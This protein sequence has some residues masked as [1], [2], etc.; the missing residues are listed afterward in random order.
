VADRAVCE[1]PYR[2]L[3][4][5]RAAQSECRCRDR[6]VQGTFSQS[7]WELDHRDR[8]GERWEFNLEGDPSRVIPH[9]RL[10]R[11][12]GLS[13]LRSRHNPRLSAPFS[14]DRHIEFRIVLL[15]I[16]HA[17]LC[18]NFSTTDFTA[19][20]PVTGVARNSAATPRA[21]MRIE[22]FSSTFLYHC[23]SEPC[24]GRR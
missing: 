6:R 17:V 20:A 19:F 14:H 1:R 18:R 11:T 7:Y 24:T 21:S 9:R 8:S 10:P 2:M 16:F 4:S 23:V 22:G 3:G 5:R 12:L 13:D 15:Y